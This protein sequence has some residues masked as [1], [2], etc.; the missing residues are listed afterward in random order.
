MEDDGARRQ[1]LRLLLAR[2]ADPCSRNGSGKSVL[3]RV[4]EYAETEALETIA[5]QCRIDLADRLPMDEI[6][7]IF[8]AMP[9][10][11]SR[12][13]RYRRRLGS[14][15]VGGF[16]DELAP[17]RLPEALL[18]MDSSGRVAANL[19]SICRSLLEINRLRHAADIIE[20]LCSRGLDKG[21]FN[22]ETKQALLPFALQLQ[23]W[24][25]AYQLL[26]E[27]PDIPDIN[28][29][30]AGNLTPLSLVTLSTFHRA[31]SP[32]VDI[33][34]VEA[35]ADVHLPLASQLVR[36]RDIDVGVVSPLKQ[37]LVFPD[38]FHID[39][40]LRKQPI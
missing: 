32:G 5:A 33:Q 37:A 9:W 2:G 25:M 36:G 29:P 38:A 20:I 23:R 1:L 4:V 10:R 30:V 12:W 17:C 35:G 18:G 19:P 7:A 13:D 8:A 31:G 3:R 16:P 24:E 11:E 14:A 6:I 40:M 27:L 21:A 28:K 22:L 39:W 26:E 34:L 15:D